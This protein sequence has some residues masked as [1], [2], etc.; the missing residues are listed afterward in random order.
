[1]VQQYVCPPCGMPIPSDDMTTHNG[2]FMH[3]GCALD[4]P[5]VAPEPDP[6]A[7]AAAD[8]AVLG[9]MAEVAAAMDAEAAPDPE[10]PAA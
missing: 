2:A 4:T 3:I 6:E 8:A 5:A 1:M 7:E 10:A 9:D